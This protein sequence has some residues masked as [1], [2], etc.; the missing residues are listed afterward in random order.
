MQPST[1]AKAKPCQTARGRFGLLRPF[2]PRN[3]PI[4]R[5]QGRL[6]LGRFYLGSPV[7]RSGLPCC[8]GDP[9]WVVL[10]AFGLCARGAGAG[11][12]GNTSAA[13][14]W[15]QPRSRPPPAPRTEPKSTPMPMRR[16]GF[17][18]CAP[19][20]R[21]A[22]S[23]RPDPTQGEPPETAAP[24]TFVRGVHPPLWPRGASPPLVRGA[25]ILLQA[26]LRAS[27]VAETCPYFGQ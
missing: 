8:R 26:A 12:Q 20:C 7:A 11:W 3:A 4:S 5:E 10:L 22:A 18:A 6:Y 13:R 19:I 17:S 16:P 25:G 9:P 24:R 2:W 1:T 21:R 15:A 23:M 27:Y 14:P